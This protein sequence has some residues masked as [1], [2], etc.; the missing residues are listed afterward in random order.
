[1]AGSERF[2]YAN[3]KVN[4]LENAYYILTPTGSVPAERVAHLKDLVSGIKAIPMVIACS[5]HDHATAAISHLPHI[6]ASS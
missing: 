4:L 1:M 2:G 5:E 6:I 3:S